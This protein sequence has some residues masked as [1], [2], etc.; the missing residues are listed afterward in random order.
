MM[1]RESRF[2]P[3]SDHGDGSK[4]ERRTAPQPRLVPAQRGKAASQRGD[5]AQAPAGRDG[6]RSGKGREQEGVGGGGAFSPS[7]RW[8]L[9]TS[10]V[11]R[12]AHD[13]QDAASHITAP[14]GDF[15]GL[16][17]FIYNK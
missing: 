17:F 1:S 7:E 16:F 10:R 15:Y 12:S 13:T 3:G 14:K 11:M 4:S 6:T 2:S 9:L 5:G 8:E